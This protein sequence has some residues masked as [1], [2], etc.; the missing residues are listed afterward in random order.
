MST[1]FHNKKPIFKQIKEQLE[2]QIL[3]HRLEEGDKAPSTNE[4]V[5]FY[6][7]NHLT[8]AKGVNE[9]VDEGILFKKR[10]V[11]MFVADGAE[12]KLIAKRRIAFAEEYVTDLLNEA[13]KLKISEE[14]LIELIK[15]RK[16]RGSYGRDH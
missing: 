14:E 2:D 11:G 13:D 15:D 5:G 8:I 7:V 1:D 16:G 6:K 4:L 10:G 12:E 9:L 3:D